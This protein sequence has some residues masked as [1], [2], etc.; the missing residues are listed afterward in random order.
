[1][2]GNFCLEN[3]RGGGQN[4]KVFVWRNARVGFQ[5]SF[6]PS[7]PAPLSPPVAD[8]AAEDDEEE[9]IIALTLSNGVQIR[10]QTESMMTAK[11]RR[12]VTTSA[13]L[14]A[15]GGGGP[16][17]QPRALPPDA[18]YDVLPPDAA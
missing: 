15:A 10:L 1:M 12:S 3:T 9:D 4:V 18:A 5:D 2:P 11:Q 7:L 17:T 16:V 8:G 13:A 14:A 6:C